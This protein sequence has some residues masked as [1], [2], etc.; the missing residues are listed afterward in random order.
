MNGGLIIP[1][2]FS[3]TKQ[4]RP[5][6]FECIIRVVFVSLTKIVSSVTRSDIEIIV[7]P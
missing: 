1:L 2:L 3:T 6:P 5:E 7:R 4:P